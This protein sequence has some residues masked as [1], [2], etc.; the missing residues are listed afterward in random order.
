MRFCRQQRLANIWERQI[1][2]RV[3][4][5]F[6]GGPGLVCNRQCN[7]RY[8]NGYADSVYNLKHG[9][10]THVDTPDTSCFLLFKTLMSNCLLFPK[11]D[12]Q[13]DQ[14]ELNRTSAFGQKQTLRDM[15]D[16][17]ERRFSG[18][19]AKLYPEFSVAIELNSDDLMLGVLS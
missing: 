4:A 6:F 2:C 18:E 9:F 10:G 1:V 8:G 17:I 13:T 7:Y 16:R 15:V 11:A 14:I 3:F 5:S 19:A 12:I